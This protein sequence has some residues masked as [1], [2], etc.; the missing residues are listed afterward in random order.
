MWFF[1]TNRIAEFLDEERVTRAA[2]ALLSLPSKP[3]LKALTAT[4]GIVLVM[5]FT[6]IVTVRFALSL[7]L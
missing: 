5:V 4:W 7:P 3:V 2:R 1:N 6:F